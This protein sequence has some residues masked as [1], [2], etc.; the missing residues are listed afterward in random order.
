MFS[1]YWNTNETVT[2]GDLLFT[3]IPIEN[4][5][6]IAKLKTPATNSGKLKIGQKVNIKLENY[7]EAEFGTLQAKVITYH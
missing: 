7:P 1:N 6:F 5:T 2:Q 4:S 3:I